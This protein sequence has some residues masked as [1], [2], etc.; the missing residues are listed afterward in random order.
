MCESEANGQGR[1]RERR[2]KSKG[3]AMT[4]K[5]AVVCTP[6]PSPPNTHTHTHTQP[7]HTPNPPAAASTR[8][9]RVTR[10]PVLNLVYHFSAWPVAAI[11]DGWPEVQ[12]VGWAQSSRVCWHGPTSNALDYRLVPW[13]SGYSHADVAG[14]AC[15]YTCGQQSSCTLGR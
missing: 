7:T 5:K 1:G 15:S 12:C 11:H 14:W 2:Q 9:R 10:V 6:P 4:I 3:R 8:L 13:D